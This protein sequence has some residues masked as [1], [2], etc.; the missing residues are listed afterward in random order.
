MKENITLQV[1]HFINKKLRTKERMKLAQDHIVV[2][3]L[4]LP[5]RS[6]SILFVSRLVVSIPILTPKEKKGWGG[7]RFLILWS[8][9]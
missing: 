4:S 2:K 3:Y 1:L 9:L 8:K 6:L 7:E 5:P